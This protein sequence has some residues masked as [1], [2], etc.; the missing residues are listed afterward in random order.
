MDLRARPWPIAAI[1]AVALALAAVAGPPL[2]RAESSSL[3]VNAED[4]RPSNVTPER[5]EELATVSA[6][7]WHLR[8]AGL[9]GTPPGVRDGIQAFGFSSATDADAL[10]VTSVWSR[11][12]YRVKKT[13]RC[14]RSRGRR[15]CRV[16]RTYVKVGD[17][18]IEKDVQF[19]TE[20]PWQPGPAYPSAAE[21]D[22]ESTILHEL[23]HFANPT[24]DT[25][26][27]GC[28]N[29]PM[30]HAISPGEFWRGTDDWLRY[31]C[32]ASTGPR[33]RRAVTGPAMRFVVREHRLPAV[34]ER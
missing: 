2:A 13:K 19:N 25:H 16:V 31:G 24:R 6:A 12:R 5:L 26:V 21:F 7:R 18:V 14:Q 29:S 17:E 23:G 4:A 27:F 20:V 22:L 10:G 15:T 1:A 28:E 30:I 11:P 32:S 3:Y 34:V 8:V 9:T 33:Q